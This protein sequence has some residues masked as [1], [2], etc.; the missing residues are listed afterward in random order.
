MS[1]FNFF[2]FVRFDFA[3]FE[4]KEKSFACDNT[5]THSAFIHR[6]TKAKNIINYGKRNFAIVR[7]HCETLLNN[8]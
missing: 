1:T 8:T 3:H 2:P 6:N 4:D 5:I 7:S